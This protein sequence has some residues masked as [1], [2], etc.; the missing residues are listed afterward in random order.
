MDGEKRLEASDNPQGVLPHNRGGMEQ[1][2]L[3]PVWCSKLRLMSDAKPPVLSSQASLILIHQP[4]EG[5]EGRVDFAQRRRCSMDVMLQRRVLQ[6]DML[7]QIF[8]FYLR[9]T[10]YHPVA[11]Q[12]P[13]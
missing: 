10:S 8:S 9:K 2:T 6:V 12:P 13:L 11:L 7:E 5:M 4:T 1:I 3:S